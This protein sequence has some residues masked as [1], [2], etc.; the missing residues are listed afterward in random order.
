MRPKSHHLPN[1]Y[2]IGPVHV[3]AC[4]L[5]PRKEEGEILICL[6]LLQSWVELGGAGRGLAHLGFRSIF[7]QSQVLVGEDH[8]ET[9]GNVQKTELEDVCEALLMKVVTGKTELKYKFD[10]GKAQ[11][12]KA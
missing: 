2:L 3:I 7:Y 9:C 11:G 5:I 4:Y 10:S 6:D 12:R 1:S 8:M